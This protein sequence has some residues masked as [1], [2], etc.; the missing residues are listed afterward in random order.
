VYAVIAPE[1]G[2]LGDG[3]NAAAA[4]GTGFGIDLQGRVHAP[5]FY[6]VPIVTID[7]FSSFIGP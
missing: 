3:I 5:H 4:A 7:Y 6:D 1:L 2:V